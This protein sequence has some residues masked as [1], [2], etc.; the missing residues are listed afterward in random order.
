MALPQTKE[1]REIVLKR[2][3]EAVQFRR[4]IDGL[5]ED[6]KALAEA[7]KEQY[8]MKPAEFK[9]LVKAAYDRAK[10]EDQIE[11]LQTALA[12]HEILTNSK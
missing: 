1:A 11:V 8:D 3:N 4:E 2:I 10:L 9:T 7:C 6:T 5:K 12:E